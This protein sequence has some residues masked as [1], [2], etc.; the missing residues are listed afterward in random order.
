MPTI[1]YIG[2][3]QFDDDDD[4]DCDDEKQGQNHELRKMISTFHGVGVTLRLLLPS[5]A[6][7]MIRTL[8]AEHRLSTL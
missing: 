6:I 7:L 3:Y 2:S 5:M 4:D 1:R 8:V